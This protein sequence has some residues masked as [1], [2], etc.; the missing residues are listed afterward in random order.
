[1]Y[2]IYFAI[3]TLV[4]GAYGDITPKN[5]VEVIIVSVVLLIGT[6]VFAYKYLFI[7]SITI[8]IHNFDVKICC[9]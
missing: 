9:K 8:I 3:S 4:T 2:S 1:M 6:G 5:P 7:F